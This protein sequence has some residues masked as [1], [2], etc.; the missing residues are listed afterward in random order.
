MLA[1]KGVD[2]GQIGRLRDSPLWRDCTLSRLEYSNP[3][4]SPPCRLDWSRDRR[5][6]IV[7]IPCLLVDCAGQFVCPS[8]LAGQSKTCTRSLAKLSKLLVSIELSSCRPL[9]VTNWLR[10]R[11]RRSSSSKCLDDL[12]LALLA[13]LPGAVDLACCTMCCSTSGTLTLVDE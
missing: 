7:K 13:E 1:C 5:L 9:E 8:L 4:V 3:S 2:S 10:R 11:R 12:G 6:D